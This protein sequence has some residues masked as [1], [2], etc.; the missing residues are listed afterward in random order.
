MHSPTPDTLRTSLINRFIFWL[1]WT[2]VFGVQAAHVKKC[3]CDLIQSDILIPI[4]PEMSCVLWKELSV[5][6]T[7]TQITPNV[8]LILTFPGIVS[9]TTP[10]KIH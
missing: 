2:N 9:G 5:S 10:V 3:A 6:H 8:R 7:R 1:N 4:E